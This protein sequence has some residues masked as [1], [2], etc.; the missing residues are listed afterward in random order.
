MNKDLLVRGVKST[1]KTVETQLNRKVHSVYLTGSALYGVSTPESDFDFKVYVYPTFSDL[2]FNEKLSKEVAVNENNVEHVS[3]RDVR[4]QYDELN[5]LSLNSAHLLHPPLLGKRLFTEE[6]LAQVLEERKDNFLFSLAGV[7][8][9]ESKKEDSGKKLSRMLLLENMFT[10]VLEDKF[11]L[12]Y[13]FDKDSSKEVLVRENFHRYTDF[14]KLTPEE[15]MLTAKDFKKQYRV[16]CKK[17]EK[18]LKN[19]LLETVKTFYNVGKEVY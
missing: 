10:A 4:F 17:L 14:A 6:Q 8:L 3:V 16:D 19:Q 1:V 12:N 11:T 9:S 18:V 15:L 13:F 5:K 7:S 2:C